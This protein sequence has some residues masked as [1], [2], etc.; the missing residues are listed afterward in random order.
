M[1]CFILGWV[2]IVVEVYFFLVMVRYFIVR[3]IVIMIEMMIVILLCYS[4]ISKLIKL[5]CFGLWFCLEILLF[6]IFII[7]LM[8]EII[9]SCYSLVIIVMNVI[10]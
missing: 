7:I 2:M 9:L 4:W 5:I 1:I 10:G 6:F 8:D 3:V